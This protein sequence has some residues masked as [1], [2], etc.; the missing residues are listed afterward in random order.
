MIEWLGKNIALLNEDIGQAARAHQSQLTKP[1]GS[2]G[3][4]E[5]LAIRLC[6]MQHTL[7]PKVDEVAIV[8]FAADHGVA[9]EGVSAF[10][11]TVTVEMMKN[12]SNGGAAICVMA[13][14][15]NASFSVVNMGA[16]SQAPQSEKIIQRPVAAGT[17]NFCEKPAMSE[18]QLREAF[19]VGSDIGDQLREE[20]CELFVA[21]EM[22]IAN[23]T[24]AAALACALLQQPP[25]ELVGLGTGVNELGRQRKISAVSRALDLHR[26]ELSDPLSIL[27]T[28]GGFEIA[29]IVASYLRCAQLGIPCL[30]DGF[31]CSVA[32]LLAVRIN[33]LCRQWLFFSHQSAELGHERV[34]LAL[35]ARPLF[36]LDLRLGEGSGAALAVPI[37]RTACDLHNRMASFSDAGVSVIL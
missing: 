30:V 35:E 36:D 15:L 28:L 14:N 5:D 20:A 12:F 8:I 23:T 26:N 31:I 10:P 2:L 22:G 11:Q 33:P 4:L 24:S 17:Q 19:E 18:K 37:I 13:E 16:A 21:G 1:V 6:S 9:V 29:A 27:R 7:N 3:M 25:H 32:A 34:L